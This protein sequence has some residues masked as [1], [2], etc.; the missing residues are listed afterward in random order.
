M[1]PSSGLPSRPAADAVATP[2]VARFGDPSLFPDLA[3]HAYLAH[4]AL[5][6]PSTPVRAAAAQ[7]LTD[8]ATHGVAAWLQYSE[9][10]DRLRCKLAALI[11]ARPEEIALMPNTSAGVLAVATSMTWRPGE[12]VLVFDGEFPTN[13]LPWQAA[14]RVHGLAIERMPVDDFRLA[15]ERAMRHFERVLSAGGVRLVA[16]S[17][18]QFQTGLRVPLA[19]LGALCRHFG[20]RLF[21][22]GIQAVGASPIDVEADGIDYLACG[23]HKWLMG[24]EGTGFL[25]VRQSRLTELDD[26]LVSWLGVRDGAE[27]LFGET[28]Q[29]PYDRPPLDE[30]RRFEGGVANASGFAG[31]E[32]SVDLLLSLGV[33]AISAHLG[34]YLDRLEAKLCERGFVSLRSTV[35]S[36]R[37]GILAVQPPIGFAVP[38]LA[39]SLAADGVAVSTPVG[40][41]RF[42]PHWPNAVAE[43]DRV[44]ASLDRALSEGPRLT[45]PS[46]SD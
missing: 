9:Q 7:A 42:A 43:V 11:G 33:E 4:A 26:R 31:L 41:L 5:S 3:P 32:A 36:A 23:G 34:G 16:I 29:L 2:A 8:C 39:E 35:E 46:Q 25:F 45:P 27:F 6:P 38:A 13:V 22:D 28:D 30:A 12:R 1:T 19:E 17:A 21:V 10:R 44:A 20:A 24:P 15:P 18:V 40:V 37:S 14:A